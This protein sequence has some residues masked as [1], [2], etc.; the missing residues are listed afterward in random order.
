MQSLPPQSQPF[1]QSSWPEVAARN[2][3]ALSGSMKWRQ[4]Y[5]TECALSGDTA[6]VTQCSIAL[7]GFLRRHRPRA[8]KTGGAAGPVVVRVPMCAVVVAVVVPVHE[9]LHQDEREENRQSDDDDRAGVVVVRRRP[10]D[11]VSRGLATSFF[12]HYFRFG[13]LLLLPLPAATRSYY[14]CLE[15]KRSNIISECAVLQSSSLALRQKWA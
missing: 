15:M 9:R 13:P 3:E 10:T 5:R 6:A 2:D 12:H 4:Q 8:P 7:S 14:Y 11:V 1:C